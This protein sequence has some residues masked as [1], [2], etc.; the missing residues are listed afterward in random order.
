MPRN[1]Q[2]AQISAFRLKRQHLVDPHSSQLSNICQNVCGIQA[3]V[4]SAAEISLWARRH[5]LTRAQI[6]AAMWKNRS[7]IKTS[8]MRQTLHLIPARDFSIYIN[9]LKSSR[10]AAL[11]NIMSLFGITSKALEAL[12]TAIIEALRG[13]PLPQRELTEHLKPQLGKNVRAWMAKVWSIFRPAIVEGLVCYGPALGNEV[14]LVRSDQW[15]PK[16]KNVAEATA[17]K[18]L[19]RRY[20]KA[21]GPVTLHDF[22]RWTGMNIPEA[23][24]VWESCKDEL[25]E[26]ECED[27]EK[28][29]LREDYV[30]LHDGVFTNDVLRLLPHFDVYLL[31][32]VGKNHLLSTPHYKRVYRNQG[33]ISPVILHN[34]RIIGVWSYTRRAKSWRLEI[35]PLEKFSKTLRAK[36]EEEAGSLGKFLETTWEIKFL[37]KS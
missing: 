35:E 18:I 28:F 31:G 2:Q 4:M 13:G 12:N 22:S 15:L 21:Y 37:P 5:D 32:H 20:L 8:V 33:W 24:A 17:K 25:R 10:M 3:Q 16:Q 11:W 1:L 36:I 27:G 7:L 30:A 14:V 6:R 26:V 29:I 19:L 34:G 23:K 9:A